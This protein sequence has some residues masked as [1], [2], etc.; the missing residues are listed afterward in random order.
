MNQSSPSGRAWRCVSREIKQHELSSSELIRNLLVQHAR[1]YHRDHLALANG[2]RVEMLLQFGC[3]F[4]LFSLRAVSLQG[5]CEQHPAD[6]ARETALLGIRLP[7]LHS[8]NTRW[9][10]AVTGDKDY[11]YMGVYRSKLAL[12]IQS[13]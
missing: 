11:R 3:F 2:Q 1:N 9:N 4:V 6:P 5:E 8:A 10:I 12:K 13:T 7:S